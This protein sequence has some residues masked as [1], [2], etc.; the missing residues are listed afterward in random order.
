[1][2]N[3]LKSQF[4]RHLFDSA[5]VEALSLLQLTLDD[6]EEG[7]TLVLECITTWQDILAEINIWRQIQKNGETQL[8]SHN[9]IPEEEELD[10][11]D[12]DKEEE[13]EEG[14]G[15]EEEEQQDIDE[16]QKKEQEIRD[17]EETI[18]DKLSEMN[19]S[20]S[21][22]MIQENEIPDSSTSLLTQPYLP[23]PPPPPPPINSLSTPMSNIPPPPPPP[24]FNVSG[25]PGL[26]PPPPPPAFGKSFTLNQ[27]KIELPESMKPKRVPDKTLKMKTLMWSKL[28]P[29]VV[30]GEGKDSVWSRLA[31]ESRGFSLDFEMI[32][33][34]FSLAAPA[35]SVQEPTASTNRR[36]DTVVDLL[37]PKRSQNVSITLKRFKDLDGLIT[38][39]Q[40]NNHEAFEAETL[41]TL[42]SILPDT[43][44][45]EALQ[46]YS[47]DINMLAPPCSFFLQ[48]LN[49]SEYSLRI[50]CMLYRSEFTR[51]I[52]E[53]VPQL[54]LL[55]KTC[56]E[57]S[58]SEALRRLLLVLVN[59]GNYL[60]GSTAHGNAAG[61]KL[62]SLWK[63]I[64]L[65]A[66]K[67][68]STLLHAV[69]KM[70]QDLLSDLESEL[71]TIQQATLISTEELKSSLRQL[72][73]QGNKLKKILE[74]RKEETFEDTLNFINT[75][76]EDQM[77]AATSSLEELLEKTEHLANYFCE[78]PKNFKLDEC[79]MIFNNF[80]KRLHVA[81]QE[82]KEREE[83]AAKKSHV[84]LHHEDSLTRE[85]KE[86]PDSFQRSE[87]YG[88]QQLLYQ[89]LEA[90]SHT[91][92]SRRR[93]SQRN[94]LD[95]ARE[96]ADGESK[97]RKIFRDADSEEKKADKTMCESENKTLLSPDMPRFVRRPRLSVHYENTS[98]LTDYIQSLQGCG[99]P[100]K[101][102]SIPESTEVEDSIS[103]SIPSES[104]GCV[105]TPGS[106]PK[107][108]SDEGFESEKDKDS[109]NNTSPRTLSE[110]KKATS[111][112][113]ASSSNGTEEKSTR[114]LK[115][116]RLVSVT[117]S[118]ITSKISPPKG[119]ATSQ[120]A[121]RSQRTPLQKQKDV[122]TMKQQIKERMDRPTEKAS[123]TKIAN[124]SSSK[125]R[126]P[127]A[128]KTNPPNVAKIS[129]KPNNTFASPRRNS[130]AVQRAIS[131]TT[132]SATL[133]TPLN[134]KLV[135]KN[136]STD[137]SAPKPSVLRK[138]ST[139]AYSS[140]RPTITTSSCRIGSSSSSS[141]NS[142]V[143]LKLPSVSTSSR[144][145]L[146]KT[147][148]VNQRTNIQALETLEKPKP[149]KKTVP[150]AGEKMKPNLTSP[151]TSRTVR[152]L[153]GIPKPLGSSC[154]PKWV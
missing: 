28:A 113:V 125:L 43:D 102:N 147:G 49:I 72:G 137:K 71:S 11:D 32:E 66:A 34:M 3:H 61:F 148:S 73:D 83:R 121:K 141:N 99:I 48:I 144:P 139:S 26:P 94:I 104:D 93:S 146:I 136:L 127:L 108:A 153:T 41:K 70:D 20:G 123:V 45:I 114:L 56:T 110:E 130:M 7:D 111:S 115:V 82:N 105:S 4:I 100:Q 151:A 65:K 10:D 54:N 16:K 75:S 124:A 96:R 2:T 152:T 117:T 53:T 97:L 138:P 77:R 129:P 25:Q 14:G 6:D 67:G 91:S 89:T 18:D 31:N 95:Q 79:L 60:N 132:M 76:A 87:S 78:N 69:A 52:E 154:R 106:S 149:L 21:G 150:T 63:M 24:I 51:V 80:I 122:D 57:L 55:L 36:K 37:S 62:N 101:N 39:L 126:Q 19:D 107:S 143:D 120:L 86:N 9:T 118:P 116:P 135:R 15:R 134:P 119:T 12:D 140:N 13:E 92:W 33:G 131:T 88:Q 50:D 128:E 47:G 1:M 84:I 44:E 81:V 85:G 142:S 38:N 42:K 17:F 5:I 27:P 58:E 22:S 64:D 112:K 35:Q 59:I 109:L 30:V 98:D 74:D 68:G 40:Q 46:R 103:V 133:K 90:G 145:A 23:P 29:S 8:I